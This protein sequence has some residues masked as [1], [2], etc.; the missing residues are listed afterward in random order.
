MPEPILKVP[1]LTKT[2]S[3]RAIDSVSENGIA[4][5]KEPDRQAITTKTDAYA[6]L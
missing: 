4:R 1:P 6:F 2:I 5:E 3:G